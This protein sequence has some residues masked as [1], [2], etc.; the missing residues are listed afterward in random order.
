MFYEE[1]QPLLKYQAQLCFM[2]ESMHAGYVSQFFLLA[3][4]LGSS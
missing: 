1:R 3:P 4:N 2:S